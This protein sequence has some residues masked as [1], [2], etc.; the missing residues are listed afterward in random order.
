MQN[1]FPGTSLHW[2]SVLHSTHCGV[3][4]PPA[5]VSQTHLWVVLGV[6]GHAVVSLA[7]HT[8]HVPGPIG[9]GT[10]AGLVVVGHREVAP[11]LPLLPLHFTHVLFVHTGLDD[12]QLLLSVHGTHVFVVRSQ[13]GRV[14]SEHVT[15]PATP[16]GSGAKDAGFALHSTHLPAFG[17]GATKH[18]GS[19]AVHGKAPPVPALPVQPTHVCWVGSHDPL[20]MLAPTPHAD[21]FVALHSKQPLSMHAGWSAVGHRVSGTGAGSVPLSAVQAVQDPGV[22]AQIGRPSGH[23]HLPLMQLSPAGQAGRPAPQ[24]CPHD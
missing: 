7:L 11:A 19:A 20:L 6:V 9:E 18:A 15:P 3:R 4:P 8:S 1:G 17:S 21:E 23:P 24:F 16:A 14:G 22:P 13:T 2:G 10:H 12:G 5:V